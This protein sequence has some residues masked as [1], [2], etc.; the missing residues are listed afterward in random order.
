MRVSA[1]SLFLLAAVCALTAQDALAGEK[2]KVVVLRE[3]SIGSSSTA[4]PYVDKLVAVA[5]ELNG[6]SAVKG[7][8]LR[9]RKHLKKKKPDYAI[10][11]LGAFLSMHEKVEV[12]GVADVTRDGGRNYYLISE[13]ASSLAECKGAQLASNHAKDKRFINKVVAGG[14][15]SLGDFEVVKTKRPVQTIKH[16]IRGKA[17]CAL[18]DDEQRKELS[19]VKGADK[20]KV[21]WTSKKLP[22]MPVVAFA[23]TS[24]GD[25]TKFKGTLS[26]ICSGRDI[27]KEVGIQALKP[28]D[29]STY[30]SV[31]KAYK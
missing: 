22:P 2:V 17:K 13:K 4:Q 15:F 27:C 1:L 23:R 12:L 28:A 26:S 16:V 19:H 3:N 8:Y 30:E 7:Y 6:W 9:N 31:I 5:A 21:I 29:V 14:D 24:A 18:V 25:R 10:M 20:I 11:S